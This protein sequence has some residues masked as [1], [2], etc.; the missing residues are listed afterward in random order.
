MLHGHPLFDNWTPLFDNR[1][2]PFDTQTPL[3]TLTS[4]TFSITTFRS[5][6]FQ[7]LTVYE[8]AYALLIASRILKIGSKSNMISDVETV[9]VLKFEILMFH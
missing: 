4:S 3:D 5:R 1:A 8:T 7:N 2:S 9:D 6:N